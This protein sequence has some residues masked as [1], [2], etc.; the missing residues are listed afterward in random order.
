MDPLY[1][2]LG[3]AFRDAWD[4]ERALPE[5]SAELWA[6]RRAQSA[7]IGMRTYAATSARFGATGNPMPAEAS[8]DAQPVPLRDPGSP[9]ASLDAAKL[10]DTFRAYMKGKFDEGQTALVL[11]T[12]APGQPPKVELVRASGDSDV[13]RAAVDDLRRASARLAAQSPVRSPRRSLWSLRL[14]VIV[15]YSPVALFTFD[16]VMPS[17]SKLVLPLG[18]MLLKRIQLEAVYDDAGVPAAKV[19]DGPLPPAAR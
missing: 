18:R 11:V 2:R 4:P 6:K 8:L 1:S 16:E 14:Q 15:N 5:T 9:S 3:M 12:E 13:D 7:A 19:A 10:R 17:S